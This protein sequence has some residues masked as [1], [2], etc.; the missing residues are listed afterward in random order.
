VKSDKIYEKYNVCMGK[1][2]KMDVT[3]KFEKLISPMFF[4]GIPVYV[5]LPR[6][7]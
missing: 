3:E 6:A 2:V 4:A 1:L 5:F 7:L